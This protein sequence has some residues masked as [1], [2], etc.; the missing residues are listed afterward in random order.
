MI[1]CSSSAENMRSYIIYTC[2]EGAKD[3][4]LDCKMRQP[5]TKEKDCVTVAKASFDLCSKLERK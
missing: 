1:G 5:Y 3:T 2:Q 4:E